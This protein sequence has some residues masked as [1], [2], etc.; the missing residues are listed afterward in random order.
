MNLV[1]ALSWFHRKVG[2]MIFYSYPE[3]MLKEEEKIRIAD[4]IDQAFEE[5]FFSHSFDNIISMNYYFE[6]YSEWARGQKEMLMISIIFYENVTPDIE[7]EVLGQCIEFSRKLKKNKEIYK[8]FYVEDE[9]LHSETSLK[10]K[11]YND[12]LKVWVQELYWTLIEKTREKS[13]E[14]ILAT[15]LNKKTVYE[16]I[17]LLSNGPLSL[18]DLEFWFK[19]E[20]PDENLKEILEELEQERIVFINDIGVENYVLL[21][22]QIIVERIPPLCIITLFEEKPELEELTKIFLKKVQN[23]FSAYVPN[24]EDSQ[25]LIK[26]VA[27]SKIYNLLCQLREG[28]LPKNKLIDA[29]G[30]NQLR[31]TLDNIKILEEADLIDEFDYKGD[32]LIILKTDIR[33]KTE[34]PHYLRKLIPKETKAKI[35]QPYKPTRKDGLYMAYVGK[36]MAETEMSP[37]E[38]SYT[39]DQLKDLFGEPKKDYR[40]LPNLK[41]LIEQ[42][43]LMELISKEYKAEE[44]NNQGS[45]KQ[46]YNKKSIEPKNKSK[47][48]KQKK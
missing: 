35:A 43:F 3:G 25:R 12:T 13:E 38:I 10:I 47:K 20:F 1:I 7:H 28:P 15:L 33:F 34:F 11:K 31:N 30:D 26:L 23:F 40:E 44:E 24:K 21:T 18:E 9:L 8:A 5:G 37:A 6:I 4:Q 42:D 27:N 32:R 48:K 39:L 41:N 19:N 14:E 22:K 45:Q 16:V 17:N 46:K 36:N 29:L 2:P